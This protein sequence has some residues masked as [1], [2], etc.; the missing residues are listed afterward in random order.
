MKELRSFIIS[1]NTQ[2]ILFIDVVVTRNYRNTD[3]GRSWAQS[4]RG[5]GS[6]VNSHEA[7]DMLAFV[8]LF[9]PC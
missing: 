1:S 8:T 2:I 7:D 6:A 9:L 4:T 5:G 3:L